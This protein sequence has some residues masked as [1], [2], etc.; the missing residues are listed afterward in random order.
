[1]LGCERAPALD[2][3]LPCS[4]AVGFFALFVMAEDVAAK[5]EH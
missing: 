3:L 2:T 5:T 1:M 4:V